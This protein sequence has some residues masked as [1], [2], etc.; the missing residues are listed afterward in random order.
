MKNSIVREDGVYLANTRFV[1][2]SGE[3]K[4]LAVFIFFMKDCMVFHGQPSERSFTFTS[5]FV[6]NIQALKQELAE[7]IQNVNDEPE[8]SISKY[9]ITGNNIIVAEFSAGRAIHEICLTTSLHGGV[10][11]T[12]NQKYNFF[13]DFNNPERSGPRSFKIISDS[14][15]SFSSF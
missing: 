7:D 12:L 15:L 11:Y 1:D 5:D 13:M 8:E 10:S 2:M 9:K 6:R 14:P 3:S 4:Y